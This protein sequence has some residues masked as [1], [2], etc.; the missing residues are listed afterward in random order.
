[1]KRH[2]IF[3]LKISWRGWWGNILKI[4]PSIWVNISTAPSI[5]LQWIGLELGLWCGILSSTYGKSFFVTP[6]FVFRHLDKKFKEKYDFQF[7]WL[8]YDYRKLIGERKEYITT[9]ERSIKEFYDEL[10]KF[11]EE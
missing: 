3:E 8:G 6:H 7:S 9:I 4:I 10:N 2:F 5:N 11:T 1:M